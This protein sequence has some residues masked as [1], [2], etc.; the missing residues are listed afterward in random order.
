MRPD[1]DSTQKGVGS[2]RL[3]RCSSLWSR[4]N[5][6]WFWVSQIIALGLVIYVNSLFND[7]LQITIVT[8]YFFAVNC[9]LGGLL[10]FELLSQPGGENFSGNSDECRDGDGDNLTGPEVPPLNDWTETN[11]DAFGDALLEDE[12]NGREPGG[13]GDHRIKSLA[14]S[15]Y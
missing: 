3:V 2:S 7:T 11:G 9:Y 1:S 13:D 4:V 6:W 8:V 10:T 12:R 15:G 5:R 14:N